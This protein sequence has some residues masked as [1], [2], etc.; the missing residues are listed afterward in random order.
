MNPLRR[1]PVSKYPL[2]PLLQDLTE[3]K[4]NPRKLNSFPMKKSNLK[5]L[6]Q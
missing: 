3:K 5:I 2:L 6:L 4:M 1:L